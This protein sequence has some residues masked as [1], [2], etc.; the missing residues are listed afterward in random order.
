MAAL[1]VVLAIARNHYLDRLPSTLTPSTASAVADIL[2]RSLWVTL[3]TVFTLGL[4]V[5]GGA[6]L[7][8]RRA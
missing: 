3:A 5:G 7:A 8:R 1:A 6:F 4:I 2:I